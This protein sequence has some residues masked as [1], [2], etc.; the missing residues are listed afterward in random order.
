MDAG[1]LMENDVVKLILSEEYM[2]EVIATVF[3]VLYTLIFFIGKYKNK[4]IARSWYLSNYSL[5]VDQFA[6]VGILKSKDDASLKSIDYSKGYKNNDILYKEGYNE[7]KIYMTGRRFCHCCLIELSLKHRHD[8]ISTVADLFLSSEKD[9]L[10]IE[11]PMIDMDPINFTIMERG[12]QVNLIDLL[13]ATRYSRE[14]PLEFLPRSLCC[15]TDCDEL[16]TTLLDSIM[17]KA[18]NKWAKSIEYIHVSDFN[19]ISRLGANHDFK[20]AVTCSIKLDNDMDEVRKLLNAIFHFIDLL[21]ET[22]ISTKAKDR[23]RLRRAKYES[24]QR[25]R[26]KTAESKKL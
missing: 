10:I 2:V 4:S 22:K 15:F 17:I 21:G 16:L 18:L 1:I 26:L 24:E 13:N 19:Y 14:I 5:L 11:I 3:L 8:L 9:R 25:R 7:Y 12:E 23:N 6:H 20:K